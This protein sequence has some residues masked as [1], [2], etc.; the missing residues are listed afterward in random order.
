MLGHCLLFEQSS[1]G[2]VGFGG[3]KASHISFGSG[4]VTMPED[5]LYGRTFGACLLCNVG[6][7]MTGDVKSEYWNWR[8]KGDE[9]KT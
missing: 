5:I 9:D 7:S 2:V 6:K 1:Q 8:K 3:V 4:E